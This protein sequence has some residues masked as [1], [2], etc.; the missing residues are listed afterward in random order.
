MLARVVPEKKEK[1]TLACFG[2]WY[3]LIA[4]NETAV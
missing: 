4:H 3:T 2:G 1:K